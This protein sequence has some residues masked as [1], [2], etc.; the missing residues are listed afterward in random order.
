MM[1][2]ILRID[3]DD[4]PEEILKIDIDDVPEDQLKAILDG[5]LEALK[6]VPVKCVKNGNIYWYGVAIKSECE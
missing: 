3:I 1:T 6:L 5:I 2:Q 4:V